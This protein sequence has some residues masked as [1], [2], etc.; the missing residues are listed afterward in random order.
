M[1]AERIFRALEYISPATWLWG[2]RVAGQRG[3]SP[4]KLEE[5]ARTQSAKRDWYYIA[6][7]IVECLC[8]AVVCA[9][10]W[11]QESFRTAAALIAAFH[12][13]ELFQ[14]TINTHLFDALRLESGAE[15][16]VAVLA[17]VVLLSVWN[18][19]ELIL[20]FG[21][22]YASPISHVTNSLT[23]WDALYFSAITQFTIGYG[24]LVPCG[25][26]RA[27]TVCQTSVGFILGL[28]ALS[29]IIAFLPKVT[30]ILERHEDPK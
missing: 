4:E 21:I 16:H 8:F 17:R 19:F 20:C 9:S 24:D 22:I 1:V 28:F 3:V 6:W 15:H 11:L 14:A 29:R 10:C 26:T 30:S 12:I 25:S 5:N 7:F 27:I 23:G 13:V 18:F 2:T